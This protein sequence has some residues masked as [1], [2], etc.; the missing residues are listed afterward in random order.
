MRSQA[1]PFSHDLGALQE[2]RP[3]LVAVDRLGHLRPAR[4]A[5]RA[6]DVLD[7]YPRRSCA[8]TELAAP[9]E[10]LARRSSAL[11]A[12]CRRARSSAAIGKD[13]GEPRNAETWHH[14]R[15][16]CEQI[17]VLSAG[18]TDKDVVRQLLEFNAYEFSRLDELDLDDHGRFGYRYLDHYWK[19]ADRHPYLIRARG[20]IAGM[21]LVREGPPCTMAEFLIM[22]KY[23]R[24]GIGTAAARDLFSRHPGRWEVHQIL[25]NDEAVGFWRRAIPCQFNEDQD[26]HGTVQR[27][28]IT[29]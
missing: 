7:R 25:G 3:D 20:R 21:A 19:E 17:E 12:S 9:Q 27:F 28:E 11:L 8:G 16:T 23:R 6:G 13:G 22:P 10:D 29:E 26:E 4:V 18:L 1:C 24:A 2:H 14:A 5:D 15:V